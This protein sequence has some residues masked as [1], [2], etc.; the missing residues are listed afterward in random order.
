MFATIPL[1]MAAVVYLDLVRPLKTALKWRLALL[2]LTLLSA[3]RLQA[4]WLVFGGTGG[5]ECPRALILST[6][7]FQGAVIILFLVCIPK[8]AAR[9]LSYPAGLVTGRRES[10]RRFRGRLE[11]CGTAAALA[12][13]AFALSGW[14]LYQ[15]ARIPDVRR[16]TLYLDGWPQALDGLKLAVISDLHVSRLFDAAWTRAVVGKVNAL[17]PDLILIPGDIVDGTPAQRAPDTAPLAGLESAYGTFMS[18][19]NHEYISGLPGWLPAFRELGIRNLYNGSATVAVKGA[20]LVVAGVTDPSAARRGLP[21]PDLRKALGGVPRGGPPV[22]LLDH[23]P[24][25]APGN[26]GDGRVSLQLSG[27]T[28]GGLMPGIASLVARYN[29]GFVRGWYKVGKLVMYVHPGTGLWSG[30]PMRIAN[31]SEITLMTVKAPP[32]PAGG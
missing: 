16:E 32:P 7:L 31:P 14:A 10:A 22:I 5:A 19:G 3:G 8:Q 25:H 1:I 29:G 12:A 21:G 30:I 26:S 2:A 11:S 15:A 17:G 6:A 28:H 23:R 18:T 9:L 4:L 24:G 13:S 20:E 27:H